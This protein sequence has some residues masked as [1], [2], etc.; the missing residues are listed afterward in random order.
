MPSRR[1]SWMFQAK[2]YVS[3][4][5]ARGF[6]GCFGKKGQSPFP[7]VGQNFDWISSI[8]GIQSKIWP[9]FGNGLWPF[10]P[11]HPVCLPA[12]H[13]DK[14]WFDR[15]EIIEGS[16]I[17]FKGPKSTRGLPVD[18]GHYD[19]FLVHFKPFLVHF[20]RFQKR[21]CQYFAKTV[22]FTLASIARKLGFLTCQ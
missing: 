3:K 15:N 17:G 18:F 14:Y 22:T 11:K 19:L 21:L 5:P 2:R 1:V 6:P 13:F 20:N 16:I 10:L 8:D 12:G 9:T 7:N 4:C